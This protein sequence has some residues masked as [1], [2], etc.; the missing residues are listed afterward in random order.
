MGVPKEIYDNYEN[1]ENGIEAADDEWK[2]ILEKMILKFREAD[3]EKWA[4]RKKLIQKLKAQSKSF[5][6]EDA[7]VLLEYLDFLESNKG[8]I[9]GS[10]V[11]FTNELHG[12]IMLHKPHPQKELKKY[13]IK[14]LKEF[15]EQEDLIWVALWNIKDISEV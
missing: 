2:K 14:Q 4:R 13:Q 10:R 1:I 6:Y 3:G 8:K 11:V 7:K 9:S 15:L 12:N 5:S